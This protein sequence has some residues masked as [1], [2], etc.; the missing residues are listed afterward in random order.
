MTNVK[1]VEDGLEG[2][3]E[4]RSTIRANGA[5]LEVE[6][7][8]MRLEDVAHHRCCVILAYRE[9]DNLKPRAIVKA[10]HRVPATSKRHFV[11]GASEVDEEV[12]CRSACPAICE[13]LQGVSP[14]VRFEALHTGGPR[15]N[16]LNSH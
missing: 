13:R 4:L 3:G 12:P 14:F 11:E 16:N 8:D 9:T 10:Q 6:G 2:F 1:L 5:H 7:G 15:T